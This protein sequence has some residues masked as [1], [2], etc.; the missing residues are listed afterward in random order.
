[1]EFTVEELRKFT[2]EE[3]QSL[4]II[5]EIVCYSHLLLY[6]VKVALRKERENNKCQEQERS[7]GI[8]ENE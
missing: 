7:A 4:R 5:S 1:M 2:V 8:T 6:A 3:L